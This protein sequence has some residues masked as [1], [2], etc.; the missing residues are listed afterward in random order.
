MEAAADEVK[1]VADGALDGRGPEEAFVHEDGQDDEREGDNVGVAGRE[2]LEP[3]ELADGEVEQD[4]ELRKRLEEQLSNEHWSSDQA[5][6]R[7]Q[8]RDDKVA[9]DRPQVDVVQMVV[10]DLEHGG[11]QV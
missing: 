9:R 1:V 5:R 3:L 10:P 6:E 7:T 4:V 8:H 11:L 2:V